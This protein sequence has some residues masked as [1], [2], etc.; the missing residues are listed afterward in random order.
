MQKSKI[1]PPAHCRQNGLDPSVNPRGHSAGVELMS[2]IVSFKQMPNL[3]KAT[4]KKML[5][6]ASDY[7]LD[8]FVQHYGMPGPRSVAGDPVENDAVADVWDAATWWRWY[9]K[10]RE[11][12]IVAGVGAGGNVVANSNQSVN[13]G[14]VER[15]WIHGVAERH[16][17]F[18]THEM[19]V[20]FKQPCLAAD[21]ESM[22][23][24]RNERDRSE[25]GR[26]ACKLPTRVWRKFY[27]HLDRAPDDMFFFCV[28]PERRG[29]YGVE[30]PWHFHVELF[31]TQSEAK[32]FEA[33]SRRIRKKIEQYLANFAAEREVDV[34]WQRVDGG[35]AGYC[36]KNAYDTIDMIECNFLKHAT[37]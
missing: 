35:Y 3:Q 11:S 14:Q 28:Y 36:Q 17:R 33:A 22:V 5:C 10:H 7:V 1:Y 15:D 24:R 32:L 25:I 23:A 18:L 21:E 6:G 4:I 9:I 31:L 19:T 34:Q 37:K 27:K 2:D 30:K 8:A 26:L 20:S 16:G 12:S 29:R 13:Y